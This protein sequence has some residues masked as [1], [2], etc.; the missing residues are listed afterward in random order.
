MNSDD[1]KSDSNVKISLRFQEVKIKSLKYSWEFSTWKLSIKTILLHKETLDLVTDKFS[2][3]TDQEFKTYHKWKK[4]NVRAV[5]M[6][7]INSEYELQERL[8]TEKNVRKI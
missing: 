3:S 5:V 2:K 6:L 8:K 1:S 4:L 7:K